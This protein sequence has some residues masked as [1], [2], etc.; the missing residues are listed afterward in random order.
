MTD[1]VE[2][3]FQRI[4]QPSSGQECPGICDLPKSSQNNPV[5]YLPY[6]RAHKS[7]NGSKGAILKIFCLAIFKYKMHD[8]KKILVV[9]LYEVN[10]QIWVL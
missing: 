1:T 5:R 8:L 3:S 4:L 7:Y 9:P 6:L 2:G 10:V